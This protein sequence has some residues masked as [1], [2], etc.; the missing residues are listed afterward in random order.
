MWKCFQ[1]FHYF[2]R[3]F[4][5]LKM[6]RNCCTTCENVSKIVF[7]SNLPNFY[8]NRAKCVLKKICTI[9]PVKLF[10]SNLISGIL[11][12]LATLSFYLTIPKSTNI[13]FE[14]KHFTNFI[15]SPFNNIRYKLNFRQKLVK[16]I[17]EKLFNE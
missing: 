17:K 8:L 2:Y 9:L 7:W 16:T 14:Y 6:L 12:N 10:V 1:C 13:N 4:F 15:P 11:C 5:Y 3:F